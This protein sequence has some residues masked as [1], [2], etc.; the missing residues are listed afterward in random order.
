MSALIGIV[1]IHAHAMVRAT[2]HFTALAPMVVPTPMIEVQ[3]IWV[4]LTGIPAIDA[5]ETGSWKNDPHIRVLTGFWTFFWVNVMVK[6][7]SILWPLIAK[8]RGAFQPYL[9]NLDKIRAYFPHELKKSVLLSFQV[10][11]RK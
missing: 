4:V 9:D 8:R 6:A 1:R 5:P 2:P 11:A 3:I 7:T 10:Q